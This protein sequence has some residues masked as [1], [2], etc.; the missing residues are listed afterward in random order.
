[1]PRASDATHRL[2]YGEADIPAYF[3]LARRFTL[4]DQSFSEVGG[5]STP[6]LVM[7][8]CAAA[9]IIAN[10]SHHYRQTRGQDYQL[11]SLPIALEHKGLTWGNYGG[12]AFHYIA[13]LAGH[14][15]NHERD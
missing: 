4:C 5:P 10:P 9:P 7:L 11:P 6:N 8:I 2:Q 13:D 1:M 15:G 14:P 12:Y 3:D